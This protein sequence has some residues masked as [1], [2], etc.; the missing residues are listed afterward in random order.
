MP[1]TPTP[2]CWRSAI[3]RR[4]Y[5]QLAYGRVFDLCRPGRNCVRNEQR[6]YTTQNLTRP[7]LWPPDRSRGRN[8]GLQTEPKCLVSMTTLRPSPRELTKNNGYLYSAS[9]QRPQMRYRVL[10]T[11]CGFVANCCGYMWIC[12]TASCSGVWAYKRGGNRLW[13][14]CSHP[15]SAQY[16][17]R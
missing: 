17:T 9:S 10:K 1:Y 6:R 2:A 4:T 16:D 12:R 7:T 3:V 15:P 11:C 8:F 5:D 14:S 13:A